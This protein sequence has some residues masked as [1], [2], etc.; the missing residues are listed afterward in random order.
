[1]A[2][3]KLMEV[4]NKLLGGK[5]NE[6]IDIDL[7]DETKE[8]KSEHNEKDE[9]TKE[10]EED[11]NKANSE[12]EKEKVDTSEEKDDNIEK[13]EK[14][15]VNEMDDIK[16]F[17]D[18]WFDEASGSVDLS[19]IKN[20][21]ALAAIQLLTNK[22]KA[23]KEQRLISDSL[24]DTLKEYSLAVSE[25]T[26]RKVLDTSGVKIDKDGKVVGVKEAI[27]ALKTKEPGFFKDKE[28]ESN[29]L[30]EG[31]NPVEKKN[32]ENVNSFSQAFRLMDEINN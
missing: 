1:M 27:E 3:M 6:E 22:Y 15:E 24:N 7:D 13:D 11:I 23:E 5:L 31:F 18:G 10:K 21:E 28:K 9:L 29:P 26:L 25:D 30:N 14:V 20:P 32:T 12:E 16:M 8:D 17:E 4:L 19:K 2:K